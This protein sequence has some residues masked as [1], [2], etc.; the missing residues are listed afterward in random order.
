MHCSDILCMY[1]IYMNQTCVCNPVRE[2][3]D[4]VVFMYNYILQGLLQT[5]IL[6]HCENHIIQNGN[7]VSCSLIV[8]LVS[9]WEMRQDFNMSISNTT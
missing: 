7:E 6:F 5:S 4:T 2:L 3:W 8:Q 9:S 1:E